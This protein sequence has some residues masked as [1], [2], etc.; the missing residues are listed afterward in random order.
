VHGTYD[1][2]AELQRIN[3]NWYGNMVADPMF[4]DAAGL[5][6]HLLSAAGFVSNGVWVTNPAV[7]YSPGIDFGPRE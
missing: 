5:D 1:T 2:L 4:V 3:T 7:G 6:F